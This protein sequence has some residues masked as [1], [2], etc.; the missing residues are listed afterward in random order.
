VR[1]FIGWLAVLHGSLLSAG[2]AQTPAASARSPWTVSAQIG[3]STFNGAATG[4]AEGGDQLQS[5]P[6]R[7]T[8]LGI[9]VAYGRAGLRLGLSARNGDAGLGVRGVPVG[10]EGESPQ[11][12]LIILEGAYSITSLAASAS[13]RIAQLR[14]GPAL[15]SSLGITLERW[16]APGTAA[17]T[18]FGAQAGVS[19]EIAL[20]GAFAA[21]I[22]GELGFT[23]KSPFKVQDLPEGFRE[24][25]TWR[26]TLMAGLC[27]RP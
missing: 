6:H 15:R 1:S 27:W 17:R 18:I 9:A 19:L 20:S 7:P 14:G 10:E 22:D 24:R 25:S 2:A 12:V 3:T 5:V 16:A 11:G 13:T 4:T 21:T 23:P 8:M 26:R